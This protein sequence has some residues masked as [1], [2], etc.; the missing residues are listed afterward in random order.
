MQIE[1]LTNKQEADEKELKSLLDEIDALK[2]K[3]GSTSKRLAVTRCFVF[4]ICILVAAPIFKY[5]AQCESIH[6]KEK[7]T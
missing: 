4:I 5:P 2:V 6:S 3:L 7:R 1:A